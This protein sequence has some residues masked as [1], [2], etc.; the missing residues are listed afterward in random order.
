MIWERRLVPFLRNYGEVNK[1]KR[2]KLNEDIKKEQAKF[3]N[4]PSM[5]TDISKASKLERDD[6]EE[7]FKSI[8]V[9][10]RQRPKLIRKHPSQEKDISQNDPS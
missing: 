3:Q 7:Q 8:Q 9:M 2:N 4:N 6:E 10:K 1:G 5:D